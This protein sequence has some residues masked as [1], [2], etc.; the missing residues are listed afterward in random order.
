[1]QATKHHLVCP[2][3]DFHADA[4]NQTAANAGHA[5]LMQVTKQV[6]VACVH[7]GQS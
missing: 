2:G 4:G 1:M 5:E 6:P 7:P 3:F